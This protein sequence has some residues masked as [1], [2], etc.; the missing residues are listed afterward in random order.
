MVDAHSELLTIIALRA[1][2]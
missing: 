2:A 1:R